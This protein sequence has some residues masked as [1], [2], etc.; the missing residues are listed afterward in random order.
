MSKKELQTY[1]DNMNYD[2][3]SGGGWVPAAT[4]LRVHGDTKSS[5]KGKFHMETLKATNGECKAKIVGANV[6]IVV[7]PPTLKRVAQALRDAAADDSKLSKELKQELK[8]YFDKINYDKL[9]GGGWVPDNKWARVN[10]DNGEEFHMET[11]KVKDG[12]FKARIVGANFEIV[13]AD[14]APTLKQVAQAL[15][16]AAGL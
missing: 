14:Q 3:L 5:V 7:A 4:W 1:F 15:K 8:T 16:T 11:M 2:N 12:G 6:E 13:V 9:T 10:G